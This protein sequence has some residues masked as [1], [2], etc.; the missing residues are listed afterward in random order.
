MGSRNSWLN[1]AVEVRVNV[2]SLGLEVEDWTLSTVGI[3][4]HLVYSGFTT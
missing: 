3:G 2:D 4:N 1:E